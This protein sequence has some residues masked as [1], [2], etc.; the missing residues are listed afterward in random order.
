MKKFIFRL[1]RFLEILQKRLEQKK[2]ELTFVQTQ[3]NKKENEIDNHRHYIHGC[4]S[5]FQKSMMSG[6]IKGEEML[7]WRNFID[8][9]YHKD[10]ILVQEKFNIE[11]TLER[12]KTEYLEIDRNIK[13]LEKLKEKQKNEYDDATAKIENGYMDEVAARRFFK[14]DEDI[15]GA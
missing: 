8:F 3:L 15:G 10:E 1:Q 2:I 11:N 14:K 4:E 9:Q 6:I 13:M 7:I 5:D 12:V